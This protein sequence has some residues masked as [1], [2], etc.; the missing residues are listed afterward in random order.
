MWCTQAYL[1]KRIREKFKKD[2]YAGVTNKKFV[3]GPRARTS[4][5]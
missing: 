4:R 3:Y 1:R 2:D 5:L